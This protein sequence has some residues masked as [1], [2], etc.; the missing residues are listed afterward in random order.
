[1]EELSVVKPSLYGER[2]SGRERTTQE[3]VREVSGLARVKTIEIM[4]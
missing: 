4:M 1:M 2:K 3:L